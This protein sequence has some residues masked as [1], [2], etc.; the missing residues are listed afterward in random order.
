MRI[1][2]S[3]SLQLDGCG[4]DARTVLSGIIGLIDG[5]NR[6]IGKKVNGILIK[7]FLYQSQLRPAAEPL[8][9]FLNT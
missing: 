9:T 4:R 2:F 8:R 6:R 3:R 1:S 7:G 5:R